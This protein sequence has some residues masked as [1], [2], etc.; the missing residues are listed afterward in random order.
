MAET[1]LSKLQNQVIKL[2]KENSRLREANERFS[3][4]NYNLK[5]TIEKIENEMEQKIRD[6]IN[7]EL[8][9][10]MLENEQLKAENEKL[11]RIL[12][13]DSDN[14]GIPTSKTKIGDT[15][16][17]P[18]SREKSE[19]A[20]GGQ[21]GHSK[22]KLE[23]FK[24]EEITDTYTY[25]I[26]NPI[27]SC[28]G[29]LKLTGKRY[30]D[31]FDI[32]IRLVKRRN[33]FCEY[34]CVC[35]GKEIKVPIPNKL[36]EEN[37]Y[38]SNAQALA[39]SLVNEGYVSFK[40]T[41][42]L[43]SG[44]TGGE[45]T[46]SEGFIAKLQKRCFDK[47]ETFDNELKKRI[48]GQKV[49]HWDDTV[50][51]INGKQ[52]CLRFYGNELL[53]YYKSHEKKDKNGLDE[54]EILNY[55]DK[56]TVVIH[57]HNKVNY[58]ADYEFTNAECC[59]HLIRDL[60]E[61]NDVLPRK[62]ID[63]LIK[64]LVDTNN[65]RKEYIGKNILLFDKEVSDKVIEEYDNIINEAKEFNKKDFNK[66]YGKDER[67]LIKRLVDYKENYL[68]WVL[69]FDVP[70]SNNLSERSLRSSKTKMK[71]SG[72]FANIQNA[73]YFARVKSYIETCKSNGYNPH[74]AL[75]KLIE[76]EPYTLEEILPVKKDD[77]LSD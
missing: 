76:D 10:L 57:D 63:D 38:G 9:N 66:Y 48:I 1:S 62:W 60:K 28:G 52:G 18:N 73:E 8:S 35:C 15:K 42:E 55:L 33:E 23:K 69:R 31:D 50:I 29:K 4:E 54:D 25:E 46:M 45:M 59:V 67:K 53:K 32:E 49:L 13:H 27:C 51:Y 41:R 47:L 77:S 44:F 64:L 39:L 71:V 3:K 22:H 36:K 2:E 7:K 12:N 72:Q 14:S 21:F 11:K 5:R 58:N 70:F 74:T 30:K 19:K 34:Q 68:L 37:Q 6:V 56:E 75:V 24:D 61:L 40:R 20:K 26:A 17:I 65:L 43:I 16:R